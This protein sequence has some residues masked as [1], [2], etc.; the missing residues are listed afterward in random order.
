MSIGYWLIPLDL[1]VWAWLVNSSQVAGGWSKPA[2]LRSL[3]LYMKMTMS[4]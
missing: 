1:M 3:S 2:C 4:A